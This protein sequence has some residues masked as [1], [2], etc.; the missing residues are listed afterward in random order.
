MHLTWDVNH[1]RHADPAGLIGGKTP[2]RAFWNAQINAT[3][4][5]TYHLWE[6]ATFAL[7]FLCTGAA[8]KKTHEAA[9][10][11]FRKLES[12]ASSA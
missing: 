5:N 6:R 8:T 9:G 3:C 12:T 4:T 2:D 10:F 1:N 11:S 7:V